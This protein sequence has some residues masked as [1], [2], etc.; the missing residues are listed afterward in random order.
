MKIKNPKLNNLIVQVA[1]FVADG[2]DRSIAAAN[3]I[4]VALD[5]LLGNEE[6]FQDC[7]T[8][9]ALYRPL[10]GEGL[11]DEAQLVSILQGLLVELYELARAGRG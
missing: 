9:L 5:E 1:A 10:G 11:V 4:E 6:R 3:G 7:V 2:G 8:A